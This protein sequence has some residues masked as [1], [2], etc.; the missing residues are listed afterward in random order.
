[1]RKRESS[2][3]PYRWSALA[4]YNGERARGI[5]HTPEWESRMAEEQRAFDVVTFGKPI[6]RE[7]RSQWR[8][9]TARNA[10]MSYQPEG[11]E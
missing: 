1:M 3:A 6:V 10:L 7:E 5:V 4:T 2:G 8:Q 11:A 9:P